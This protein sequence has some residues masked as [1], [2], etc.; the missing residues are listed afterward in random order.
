MKL[1][2]KNALVIGCCSVKEFDLIQRWTKKKL[3]YFFRKEH[4][5]EMF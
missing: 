3:K 2:I 4:F 5:G 1:L